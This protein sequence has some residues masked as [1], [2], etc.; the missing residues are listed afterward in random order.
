VVD[1]K[2]ELPTRTLPQV[3]PPHKASARPPFGGSKSRLAHAPPIHAVVDSRGGCLLTW[4]NRAK[5]LP[6]RYAAKIN[7]VWPELQ[8]IGSDGERNTWDR[9]A[10]SR[11]R[12]PRRAAII[13]PLNSIHH[14]GLQGSQPQRARGPMRN[15]RRASP[16]PVATQYKYN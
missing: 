4:I 9:G 16:A 14:R 15:A 3:A 7:M 11:S 10:R 1:G 8:R 6:R 2:S 5:S 12:P 13:V